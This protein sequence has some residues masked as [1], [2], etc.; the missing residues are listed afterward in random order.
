[1]AIPHFRYSFAKGF[2]SLTIGQAREVRS[3]IYDFLGCT[4]NPTY[5]RLKHCYRDIP[6]HIYEGINRIFES[7]GVD[8]GQVWTIEQIEK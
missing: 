3:K 8:E 1:M 2:D 7:H 4:G 5:S 6:H